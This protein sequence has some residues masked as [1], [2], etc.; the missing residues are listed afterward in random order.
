MNVKTVVLNQTSG[1]KLHGSQVFEDIRLMY[2]S[3]PSSPLLGLLPSYK[4]TKQQQD[5]KAKT[6][7][8]FNIV[9]SGHFCT[10]ALF[11][12]GQNTNTKSAAM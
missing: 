6:K 1:H 4:K 3:L 9:M 11:S 2:F 8:R 5:K 7:K 12:K 10:F